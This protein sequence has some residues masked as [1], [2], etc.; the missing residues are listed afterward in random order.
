MSFDKREYGVLVLSKEDLARRKNAKGAF[1]R[2]LELETEVELE[3]QED[4]WRQYRDW[5]FF[6]GPRPT[7]C[8]GD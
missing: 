8:N 3:R 7:W 1:F 2:L 4:R 6:G 5:K